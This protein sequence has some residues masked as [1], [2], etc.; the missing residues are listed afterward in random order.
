MIGGAVEGLEASEEGASA[1]ADGSGVVVEVGGGDEVAEGVELP[2]RGRGE[3]AVVECGSEGG[4]HV[5]VSGGSQRAVGEG[6]QSRAA[7]RLRAAGTG[8][9]TRGCSECRRARGRRAWW[10]ERRGPIGSWGSPG[11]RV[12]L[13]LGIGQGLHHRAP[14]RSATSPDS[15]QTLS[16]YHL[17]LFPLHS[18]PVL[19]FRP[20]LAFSQNP[21]RLL[22]WPP[23]GA[24][25]PCPAPFPPWRLLATLSGT[26]PS[27][28]VRL[29]SARA[30][31]ILRPDK[32]VPAI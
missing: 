5:R 13:R 28:S 15:P 22:Q 6:G 11:R 19:S 29:P 30:L 2:V 4:G 32:R 31:P 12:G 17:A 7:G 20:P 23:P 9:G 25:V 10:R 14:A 16:L 18:S 21:T 27:S 26:T 3:G 24:P 8:S 1:N